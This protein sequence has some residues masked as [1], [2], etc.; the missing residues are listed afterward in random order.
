[1]NAITCLVCAGPIDIRF[2]TTGKKRKPF[3]HL[4]CRANGSH[5]RTFINDREFV[6]RMLDEAGS[7]KA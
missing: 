3:I 2:G 7:E 6:E 4:R 1:M 5:F